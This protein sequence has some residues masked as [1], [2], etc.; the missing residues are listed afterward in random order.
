[1]RSG[2]TFRV[3]FVILL[4][5]IFLGL[6]A[7]MTLFHPRK[8][9]I[10]VFPGV[11]GFGTNT[12]AGRG[13]EILKVTT[14]ADSGKGSLREA[15]EKRS[16]RIVVFEVGGII[17]LEKELTVSRP[18]LTVA[19]QT[20]PSPGILLKG[21][22]IVVATHDVLI[23]HLRIRCGDDPDGPSPGSRDALKIVNPSENVV[24]D[25]VSASWA[26]DENMA[27]WVKLDGSVVKNIT[28]RNSIISEG[29]N[30]SIH[31]EGAHSKG[32][33]IGNNIENLSLIGNLFAH[34]KT[35]NP[36]VYGNVSLLAANN[37]FYNTG[38]S[39]FLHISDGWRQG[40]TRAT[41]VGNIFIDGPDTPRGAC[42]V[43]IGKDTPDSRVF[44][45]GNRYSGSILCDSGTIDPVAP[46]PSVW[47][48]SLR[49]LDGNHAE[50]SI[51]S[52]SGARPADRDPVDRRVVHEAGTGTG[53]I[54]DSPKQVGGWPDLGSSF[55]SF[56]VPENPDGDDDGD[57]YTN[58]EE[59]LHQMAFQ[60]EATALPGRQSA[61]GSAK[62]VY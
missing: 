21:A 13:G 26:T 37:V 11:Q 50:T 46:S 22:G 12:P 47:I 44:L 45:S 1:M 58:I 16:P 7:C 39:S 3:T 15:L 38:S 28:I 33:L 36:L 14:L 41:I 62:L 27:I 60:V 5:A 35:R 34:N 6:L 51:L 54:I 32:F 29:L 61:G 20:A 43:K 59:I 9:Q 4:S 19:G 55:R 31:P 42:A 48:K 8:Q 17:S 24:I 23:Q 53:R 49:V 57:G 56:P 2:Q 52:R 40:P 25:H 18:Y 30:N 10:P